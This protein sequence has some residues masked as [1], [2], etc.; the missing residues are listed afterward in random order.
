M[1]YAVRHRASHEV[2]L[3]SQTALDRFFDNRNPDDWTP[4][5]RVHPTEWVR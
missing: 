1:H 3:I 4:P 2:R 5:V